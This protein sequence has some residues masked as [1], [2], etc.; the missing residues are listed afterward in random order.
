[1][2][3]YNHNQY[4]IE[5]PPC[6]TIMTETRQITSTG[7]T[8]LTTSSTTRQNNGNTGKLVDKSKYNLSFYISVRYIPSLI[9]LGF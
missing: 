2:F 7:T 6:T 1:M 5:V 8:E 9:P 3:F 4:V